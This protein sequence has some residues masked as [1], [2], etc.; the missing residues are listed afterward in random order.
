MLQ[1]KNLA[2]IKLYVNRRIQKINNFLATITCMS[3]QQQNKKKG[4]QVLKCKSNSNLLNS[5]VRT[6]PLFKTCFHISS[7]KRSCLKY[8]S[9]YLSFDFRLNKGET[10]P[11]AEVTKGKAKQ[12]KSKSSE[13]VRQQQREAMSSGFLLPE[14][15]TVSLLLW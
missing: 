1:E 14:K 10:K 4:V 12:S 13:L 8:L 3:N 5:S 7:K 9:I 15:E 6:Q 2:W 11:I